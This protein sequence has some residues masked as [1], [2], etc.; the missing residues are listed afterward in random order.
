MADWIGGMK[1]VASAID[2]QFLCKSKPSCHHF[3]YTGEEARGTDMGNIKIN[4][5]TVVFLAFFKE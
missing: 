2:C 4:Y 5:Y 3:S 1:N